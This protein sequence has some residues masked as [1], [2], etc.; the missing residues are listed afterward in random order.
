MHDQTGQGF[1]CPCAGH[2]I[3]ADRRL[4]VSNQCKTGALFVGHKLK[5][6]EPERVEG[7]H[8]RARILPLVDVARQ[9]SAVS[10]RATCFSLHF[11]GDAI[12][13]DTNLGSR[14]RRRR[15][16]AHVAPG[17]FGGHS[18]Q[19]PVRCA[20]GIAP[21][22]F[23]RTEEP[24]LRHKLHA[25]GT[26]IRHADEVTALRHSPVS[27]PRSRSRSADLALWQCLTE[28]SHARIRDPS[29]G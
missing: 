19:C 8:L 15:R 20:G 4:V 21:R 25:A 11:N 14:Y 17:D 2:G 22:R 13:A 23:M 26:G 6:D 24:D 7:L 9:P 27:K 12:S 28:F 16:K 29:L 5:G 3:R 1:T 18:I 10:H